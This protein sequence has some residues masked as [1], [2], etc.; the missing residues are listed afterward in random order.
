MIILIICIIIICIIY[1]VLYFNTY[2]YNTICMA[3]PEVFIY[4][5]KIEGPSI[6]IIGATHGNEPSGYVAIKHLMDLYNNKTYTLKKGKLYLI[7][8]VNYCGLKLNIRNGSNMSL[9]DWDNWLQSNH[10]DINRNYIEN[11]SN[12]INK[13]VLEYATK[14][15][16]VLDFHEGWGYHNNSNSIGSTITP[17]NDES[18]KIAQKMMTNINN[19]ITDD[20]KKFAIRTNDI[21]LL[22][23]NNYI[24]NTEIKGTLSDYIK[25]TNY[26]LIEITGQSNIISMDLRLEQAMVFIDTLLDN[27]EII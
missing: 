15:D 9:W 10:N 11:T 25:N 3:E 13:K 24:I 4:D 12:P 23:D 6:C 1:I 14:S 26:I 19:I 21:E 2:D 20:T 18:M 22:K 8:V 7:P 17:S 27:Y 16:F 5:S